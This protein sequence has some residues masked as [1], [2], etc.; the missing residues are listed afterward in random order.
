MLSSG[1]NPVLL[2]FRLR[3]SC[4]QACSPGSKI[5]SFDIQD[6]NSLL[7]LLGKDWNMRPL[8]TSAGVHSNSKHS[9]RSRRLREKLSTQAPQSYNHMYCQVQCWEDQALALVPLHNRH[10]NYIWLKGPN[11]PYSHLEVRCLNR[12]RYPGSNHWSRCLRS[13]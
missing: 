11:N 6:R 7:L 2:L 12:R 5:L 1:T 10:L 13:L 8:P 3:M 4:L 9:A